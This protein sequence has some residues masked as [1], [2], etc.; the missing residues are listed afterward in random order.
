MVY[1][2]PDKL[3]EMAKYAL[4]KDLQFTAHSVGDGAV[5]RLVDTYARIGENDFP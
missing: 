5:E 2:E 1:V 4:S 3:Y